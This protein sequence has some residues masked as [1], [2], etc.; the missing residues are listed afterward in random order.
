[1]ILLIFMVFAT[2]SCRVI[3]SLKIS[4]DDFDL[5]DYTKLISE[6]H[7]AV[8]HSVVIVLPYGKQASS[9]N[10][11]FYLIKNLHTSVKWSILVF[12]AR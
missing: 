12:N 4:R 1:M 10:A 11:L 8:G 9:Y 2:I 5:M 6:E 3:W 7:F